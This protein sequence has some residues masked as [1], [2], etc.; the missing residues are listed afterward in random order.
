MC[1]IEKLVAAAERIKP[2]GDKPHRRKT[3]SGRPSDRKLLAQAF[4]CQESA[5][6]IDVARAHATD[7][8]LVDVQ[9]IDERP[10]ARKVDQPAEPS[11]EWPMSAHH[12]RQ[13]GTAG[14]GD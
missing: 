3:R 13:G 12:G 14:R 6:D 5:I 7:D 9:A 8:R 2:P 4:P 11:E 10:D 1:N